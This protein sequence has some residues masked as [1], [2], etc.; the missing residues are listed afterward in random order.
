M[1]FIGIFIWLCWVLS[2]TALLL[3][4]QERI[5]MEAFMKK[6]KEEEEK[7]LAAEKKAKEEEAKKYYFYGWF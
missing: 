7:R 4:V 1:L 3:P 6:V 2:I 5:E